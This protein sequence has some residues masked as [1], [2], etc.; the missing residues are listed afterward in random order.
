VLGG[1]WR[2]AAWRTFTDGW[3]KRLLVE[4]V[5]ISEYLQLHYHLIFVKEA[6]EPGWPRDSTDKTLVSN[7]YYQLRLGRTGDVGS[8]AMGELLH[9][10]VV[11]GMR[12]ESAWGLTQ[13]PTHRV[14]AMDHLTKVKS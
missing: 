13:L 9:T 4:F 7:V 1:N 8:E 5:H 3:N 10:G 2:P 12:N 11:E 6:S 14:A